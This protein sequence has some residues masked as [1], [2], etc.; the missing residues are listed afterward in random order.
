MII[1]N[2]KRFVSDFG[3]FR[4]VCGKGLPENVEI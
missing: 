4:E 3:L 1:L 2:K